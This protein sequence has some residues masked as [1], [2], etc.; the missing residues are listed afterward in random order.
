MAIGPSLRQPPPLP[1]CGHIFLS[2]SD[3]ITP[4][5]STAQQPNTCT[6]H[7]TAKHIHSS[8]N[9][10][11]HA[12]V[13]QQPNTCTCHSTAKH[14]HLSLNSQTHAPVTQ[15]PNTCTRHSTAKHVHPSLNSQTHAPVTQQPNTRTRHSTAKH[16]HPS[17]NSQTHAPVKLEPSLSYISIQQYTVP[18]K[19]TRLSLNPPNTH[20]HTHIHTHLPC[21]CV[22]VQIFPPLLHPQFWERSGNV[23]ALVRLLQVGW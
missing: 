21:V 23:P 15:Q 11:T 3:S 2:V 19:S 20:T 17:L 8:L 18:A 7:S 5:S 14:M 12:P 1:K 4:I 9:S 6:C 10:Q 13:T 22:P 16:T